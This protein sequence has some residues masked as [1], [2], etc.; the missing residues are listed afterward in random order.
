M[1]VPAAIR[2]LDVVV[3]LAALPVFV[4][5]DLPLAGYAAVGCAWVVQR[6]IQTVL[7]RRASASEDPR[8]I[9]GITAGGMIL[10]AWIVAGAVF[11]AG[12]TAGD[13]AGLSAALLAISLF[14]VY[15]AMQLIL[16]P[17]GGEGGRR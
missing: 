15:F 3:L 5:A 1:E 6:A 8:T 17:I 7:Q 4:L 11:T 16:R 9:A 10:R 12:I 14:T 13:E 2:F